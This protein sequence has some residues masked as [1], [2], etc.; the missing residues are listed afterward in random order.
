MSSDERKKAFLLKLADLCE[1]YRAGFSFSVDD[2][3][4]HIEIDDEEEVFAWY[5]HAD[6]TAEE[7]RE[8]AKG[9]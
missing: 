9:L 3:L 5:G 6:G 7:M 8:A 2:D 4:I 1:E